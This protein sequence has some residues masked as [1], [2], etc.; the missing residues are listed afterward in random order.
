MVY[1]WFAM[2]YKTSYF[3]GVFGYVLMMLEFF[4]I[5]HLISSTHSISYV[6][7]MLLFYGLYYGVLSRDCAEVCTSRM[8]V[9]MGIRT[10]KNDALPTR[11]FNPEVCGI[12]GDGLK[13]SKE[14]VFSLNCGHQ[15][16]CPRAMGRVCFQTYF[17]RFHESCI[18][19]WTMIGKKDTWW[20]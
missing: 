20:V 1:R 14:R 5:S 17:G 3:I 16:V 2:F 15:Y 19:G 4:G 7:V 18:R 8:A 6:G 9:S 12:C 11:Q 13:S 10:G